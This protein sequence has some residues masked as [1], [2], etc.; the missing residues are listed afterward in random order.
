MESP[1]GLIPE[2]L[3]DAGSK[4]QVL[5]F[6]LAQTWPGDFK[7]QVLAGWGNVTGS[8]ITAADRNS[9]AASGWDKPTRGN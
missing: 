6:L 5:D 4:R 1:T 3:M 9:V 8:T 2:S 7:Q